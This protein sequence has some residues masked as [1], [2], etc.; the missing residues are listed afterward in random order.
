MEIF[1]S[2]FQNIWRNRNCFKKNWIK[3]LQ[4]SLHIISCSLKLYICYVLLPRRQTKIPWHQFLKRAYM[5]S[6]QKVAAGSI[7]SRE[8]KQR[9]RR[10]LRKRQ[11]KSVLARVQTSSR[12]FHLVQFVKCWRICLELDSKRLYQSSGEAK[13]GRCLVLTSSKKT[14]DEAGSRRSRAATARSVHKEWW[15]YRVVVLPI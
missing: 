13:E 5:Y 1:Q 2:V 8:L 15:T 12:L 3:I 6:Y 4:E 14:W 10:R 11:L 9:R 7:L